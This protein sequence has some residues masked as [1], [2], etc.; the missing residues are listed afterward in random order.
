MGT[1]NIIHPSAKIDDNVIL[2]NYNY[3]GEN[4]I[5]SGFKGKGEKV[6]IG[7]CNFI[8]DNTRILIGEEGASVGDWNVFHNNILMMGNKRLDLGHNCWFGQNTILDA[9]GGLK[10]GNGVRVGMYSQIWTHVASGELI[11]GCTLFGERETVIEDEVWLVGSCVVASGLK[12]G[13]RSTCLINSNITK[14]TEPFKVY[15]GNP[16][17]LLEKLSFWKDVTSED[18]F[19]MMKGWAQE[20]QSNNNNTKFNLD[21]AS[22]T[23]QL[24][25]SKTGDLLV[26]GFDTEAVQENDN[27]TYFNLDKKTYTKTLSQLERDFYKFIFGNKA[28][29]LPI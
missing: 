21:T 23:M 3:I 17:K 18:K 27:T 7:D 12:L 16:S 11:E 1:G 20:Y 9:S 4:V 13:Y 15:G 5:I 28:R 8:H 2:G 10:I 24:K 29:F 19:E 6:Y 25:D 22:K 26:F 14:N